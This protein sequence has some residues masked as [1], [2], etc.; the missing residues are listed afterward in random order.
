MWQSLDFGVWQWA[1]GHR[2]VTCTKH[3]T[4]HGLPPMDDF[5]MLGSSGYPHGSASASSSSSYSELFPIR[6][7]NGTIEQL[8]MFLILENRSRAS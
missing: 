6:D 4:R 8:I 1:Y 2:R 7:H 3:K 5:S